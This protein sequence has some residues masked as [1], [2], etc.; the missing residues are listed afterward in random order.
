M[1]ADVLD[2]IM[3]ISIDCYPL[4]EQGG[5][6]VLIKSGL[7]VRIETGAFFTGLRGTIKGYSVNQGLRVILRR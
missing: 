4:F 7:A 6:L 5:Y 2:A 1:A 3:I